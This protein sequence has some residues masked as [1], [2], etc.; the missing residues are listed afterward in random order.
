[1]IHQQQGTTGGLL[2]LLLLL[3][4]LSTPSLAAFDDLDDLFSDPESGIVED[5]II[6]EAEDEPPPQ[7]VDV[8]ALTTSPVRFSGSVDTGAGLALGLAEWPGSRGAGDAS[9]R[10][11]LTYGAGYDMAATFRI[12]A[13]PQPYLRFTSSL[14]T[15]LQAQT[16]TFTPL[17]IG[18]LFV[19]YTLQ[20]RIFFRVGKFGQTWGQA[21]ILENIGNIAGDT[22]NGAALRAT[23]PVGRGTAT[24]LVYSRGRT[25]VYSE[26]DPRSFTYAGQFETTRGR[27]SS[28]VA[29]RVRAQDVVRATAHVTLGLGHLDLTQE[30]LVLVDRADPL[31]LDATTVKALSQFVWEGGNP[32]WRVIGEYLFDTAVPDWQG[33]R[34]ALGVR[35]PQFLPNRWRPNVQWRHAFVDN[36]GQIET[37]L[38]GTL[39]PSMDGSIG[40]PVIYGPP[41]SV[42]RGIDTTLPSN[43]V[44]S[45]G[46]GA[47][48]KFSF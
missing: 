28:G 44:V 32:V 34:V 21:R 17:R 19:D 22:E 2:L 7:V 23:V 46:F 26:S 11:L 48:L 5:E 14:T 27:V 33:H 1:M 47:W 39:A 35:M 8:A 40:I 12:T 13:R 41:G 36:S 37:A 9:A 43:G 38:T 25:A 3:L 16:A 18:D 24:A 15:E 6:E 30:A 42:Y 29:A 10:E 20:D 31:N 45:V 4:L